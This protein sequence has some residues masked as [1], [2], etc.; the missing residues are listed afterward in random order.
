M[1]WS[2]ISISLLFFFIIFSHKPLTERDV[3]TELN[4]VSTCSFQS[5]PSF[6]QCTPFDFNSGFHWLSRFY[7]IWFALLQ[8]QVILALLYLH[9]ILHKN[10]SIYRVQKSEITFEKGFILQYF[11]VTNDIIS[12]TIW[13][14][15]LYYEI[16]YLCV[17]INI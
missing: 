7:L 8:A 3:L 5:N 12:S 4:P 1:Y 16:L 13:G 17:Y 14:G 6:D 9:Q 2:S 10:V 15:K 11:F